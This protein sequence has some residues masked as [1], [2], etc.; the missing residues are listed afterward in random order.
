MA[1]TTRKR[2]TLTIPNITDSL[3]PLLPLLSLFI[4]LSPPLVLLCTCSGFSKQPFKELGL[5]IIYSKEERH[6]RLD[7]FGDVALD[8]S[9]RV[10]G[11]D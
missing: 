2:K 7:N 4:A 8:G 3:T 1:K 5:R 9:V 6:D 10:F 11:V